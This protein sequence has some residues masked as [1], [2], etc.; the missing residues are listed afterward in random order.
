M[1][2][3]L[4][5]SAFVMKGV[6][7]VSNSLG[8]PSD[9]TSLPPNSFSPATLEWMNSKRPKAKSGWM[10]EIRFTSGQ[11]R[12]AMIMPDIASAEFRLV[13]RKVFFGRVTSFSNKASVQPST[14][15]GRNLQLFGDGGHRQRVPG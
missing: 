3:G 6:K 9:T 7:S 10:C 13:M 8:H 2:S 14:T 11:A 12:A 5:E 4:A 1:R 15:K